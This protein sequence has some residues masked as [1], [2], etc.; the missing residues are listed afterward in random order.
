MTFIKDHNMFGAKHILVNS[1]SEA[2]T[3]RES[4]LNGKLFEDIAMQNSSCPS[5]AHGGDLG[6]FKLGQ[7]VKPFEEAV[8]NMEIGAISHPVQTQFGYHLIKRTA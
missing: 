8:V 6:L 5:K 1:L 2:V 3:H 4:I 7:M